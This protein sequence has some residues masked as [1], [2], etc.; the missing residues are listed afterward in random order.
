MNQVI[1]RFLHPG[2]PHHAL[3]RRIHE[4]EAAAAPAWRPATARFFDT[5]RDGPGGFPIAPV[6]VIAGATSCSSQRAHRVYRARPRLERK[7][8]ATSLSLEWRA[9]P[10]ILEHLRAG[11]DRP[12]VLS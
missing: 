4:L 3:H 1:K 2:Q 10:G 7:G 5:P 6:V 8:S 9:P 11:Q 12:C